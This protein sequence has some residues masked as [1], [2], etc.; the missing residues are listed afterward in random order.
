MA[1]GRM[2]MLKIGGQPMT[3]LVEREQLENDLRAYGYPAERAVYVT[4][5]NDLQTDDGPTDPM[6]AVNPGRWRR[7]PGISGTSG[8]RSPTAPPR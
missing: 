7:P 2:I 8:S 1:A 3:V 5:W 4:T 6:A